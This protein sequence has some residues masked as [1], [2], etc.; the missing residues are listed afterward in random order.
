[1]AGRIVMDAVAAQGVRMLPVDSEH[2]AIFQALQ[3]GRREDVKRS[4]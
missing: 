3:A 1:M 4:S 2:S